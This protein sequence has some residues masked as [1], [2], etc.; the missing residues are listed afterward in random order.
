MGKSKSA[1]ETARGRPWVLGV[2]SLSV[3][4]GQG[5]S[6]QWPRISQ[7]RAAVPERG[8]APGQRLQTAQFSE[9]SNPERA[10]GKCWG[11]GLSDRRLSAAQALISLPLSPALSLPLSSFSS[12]LP[13]LS[14]SPPLSPF[15]FS[16]SHLTLRLQA[17]LCWCL[18][19][20]ALSGVTD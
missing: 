15:S 19:H 5:A 8:R 2:S 14:L 3:P 13:S 6:S 17:D 9:S 12:P 10:E 16:L 18:Q 4:Q 1:S 20:R 11:T 7:V